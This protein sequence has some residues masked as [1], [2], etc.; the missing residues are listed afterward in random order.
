M[1]EPIRCP[2]CNA[3]TR[4]PFCRDS[5]RAFFS[6][7]ICSLIFADPASHLSP[8]DEKARYDHHQNS[9]ADVNYRRFLNRL[10]E[11]LIARLS[12]KGLA[13]LDYGCGPGPTLSVM[14]GEAGYPTALYDP[15]YA[16][17][18]SVLS[19][20]YDFIVCT[21]AIE[22]FFQPGIEWKRLLERLN[23]GGWLGIMTSLAPS[24]DAFPDWHY[25]N[26]PTH[27]SFFRRETFQFLTQRDGLSLEI[28]GNDV[29]IARKP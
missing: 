16:P 20:T 7:N 3:I 29:I 6:C 14:L 25:K 21:E 1:P 5:A 10:A 12:R 23:P 26:D 4:E 28:I 17:D 8:A 24:T 11:P 2:L 22:H 13:G 19:K 15:F 27:V 9:P 18:E